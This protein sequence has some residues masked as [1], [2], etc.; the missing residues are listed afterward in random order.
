PLQP[1]SGRGQPPSRPRRG[2][3]H[4]QSEEGLM[5]CGNF[6]ASIVAAASLVLVGV[7]PAAAQCPALPYLLSNGQTAD[8]N[9]VMAN[10]E[11]LRTCLNSGEF[12]ETPTPTRQFSGPGGGIITMQN[13]SATTNYNFNLPSTAGSAGNFLTSG[14]GGSSSNTWTS[15]GTDL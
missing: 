3:G 6:T 15:V 5:R 12:V 11:A 10:Y 13:L 7:V 14:G 2:K 8:A 1:Y 9:Q 4:N